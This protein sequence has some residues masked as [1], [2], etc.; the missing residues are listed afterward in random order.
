MTLRPEEAARY[1]SEIVI[2]FVFAPH[3]HPAK[4]VA[5][6]V[7]RELKMRTVFNLLGPL[8]NPAGARFQ[9]IGAPSAEAGEVMAKALAKLGSFRTFIVHGRDGLAEI[10]T[11]SETDVWGG[12]GEGVYKSG[13]APAGL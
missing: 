12:R 7:R 3:L 8:V 9:L 5:Q 10:T 13:W 2:G 6:P 1:I 11:T 4:K